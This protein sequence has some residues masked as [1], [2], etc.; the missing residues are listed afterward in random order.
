MKYTSKNPNPKFLS[1]IFLLLFLRRVLEEEDEWDYSVV[2]CFCFGWE[3]ERQN[4]S[5]SGCCI[6][7][8]PTRSECASCCC[9]WRE[10]LQAHCL[11]GWS[12][13]LHLPLP[14]PPSHRSGWYLSLCP[15]LSV[16]L[17]LITRNK[18]LGFEILLGVCFPQSSERESNHLHYFL[19]GG[20]SSVHAYGSR[21]IRNCCVV[22]PCWRIR[23]WSCAMCLFPTIFWKR[24]QSSSLFSSRRKVFCSCIWKQKNQELLVV[25]LSC[26]IKSNT[27]SNVKE[28]GC[29]CGNSR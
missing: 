25:V 28:T 4:V 12:S 3:G 2:F 29:N 21:R 10:G 8:F 11:L 16:C 7:G 9:C 26:L 6:Y 14:D 5:S 20:K 22:V 18:G 17:S 24:K 23:V 19:Q 1:R 27:F 15:S 13:R